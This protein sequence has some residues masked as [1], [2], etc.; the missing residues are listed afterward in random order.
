MKAITAPDCTLSPLRLPR[1]TAEGG[2]RQ[3]EHGCTVPLGEDR[4]RTSARTSPTI[5]FLMVSMEVRNVETESREQ[6][7]EVI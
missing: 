7:V 1:L 4:G 5:L 2:H 3:E 6:R